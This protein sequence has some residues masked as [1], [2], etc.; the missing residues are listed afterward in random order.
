MSDQD[1]LSLMP[2]HNVRVRVR[3]AHKECVA[4][5]ILACCRLV[6]IRKILNIIK[7]KR[8]LSLLMHRVPL[9][10]LQDIL[11][12]RVTLVHI[13]FI[14]H[15]LVLGTPYRMSIKSFADST[16]WLHVCVV[17]IYLRLL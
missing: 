5:S 12:A 7:S 14:T 16:R 6:L 2:R 13:P 17:T 4:C 15:S 3:L 1:S 8:G 11:Q 10:L 9:V